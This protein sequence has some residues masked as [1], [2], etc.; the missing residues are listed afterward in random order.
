MLSSH[1]FILKFKCQLGFSGYGA[2]VTG[3][4]QNEAPVHWM[5]LW[6]SFESW[7]SPSFRNNLKLPFHRLNRATWRDDKEVKWGT[8]RIG[9]V[10]R[11]IQTDEIQNDGRA[12]WANR[13][14]LCAGGPFTSNTV[15]DLLCLWIF[16]QHADL[17]QFCPSFI[18]FYFLIWRENEAKWLKVNMISE[19]LIQNRMYM[20]FNHA[21]VCVCVYMCTYMHVNKLVIILV[22]GFGSFTWTV[23]VGIDGCGFRNN[24]NFRRLSLSTVQRYIF[25]QNRVRCVHQFWLIRSSKMNH[26]LHCLIS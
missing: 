3:S 15:A 5:C 25:T 23:D 9:Y 11:L 14:L 13:N 26:V 16:A 2:T 8:W 17:T 21:C 19:E 10:N 22:V 6:L 1:S 24:A 4:H 20:Q 7:T 18:R 12:V